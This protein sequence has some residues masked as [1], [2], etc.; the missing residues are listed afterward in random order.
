MQ[1]YL[2]A[3]V[4]FK[5]IFKNLLG[6]DILCLFWGEGE[7]TYLSLGHNQGEDR[8]RSGALVIHSC[9]CCGSLLVAQLQPTLKKDR[10]NYDYSVI[11]SMVC[12]YHTFKIV[13]FIQTLMFVFHCGLDDLKKKKIS[14]NL[15]ECH[16]KSSRY[17]CEEIKE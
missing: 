9:S 17:S 12:L 10:V 1:I 14:F 15:P 8:V 16:C 4:L 3:Q 7:R 5:L 13:I 6:D 11:L 2:V